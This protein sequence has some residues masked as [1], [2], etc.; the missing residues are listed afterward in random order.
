MPLLIF[1]AFVVGMVLV[2][3]V[4]VRYVKRIS[5]IWEA[6]AR[7]LGLDFEHPR[8]GMPRMFGHIR[9]LGVKVDVF[10]QRS[11]KNSQTF[12]RYR[13]RFPSPGFDFRLSRQTG[14]SRISKLFGAQDVTLG[15]PGFDQ[16]FIVKTGDESRL[17]AWL[18]PHRRGVLV[19]I[20]SSYPGV[21][22]DDGELRYQKPGLETSREVLVSTVRR[23]VDAADSLSKMRGSDRTADL[24]SARARGQLAEV[25]AR[26]RAAKE[27]RETTLDEAIVEVDTL[28][29]AGRR[30][31]ARE[32]LRMLERELPRDPEVLGWKRRLEAAPATDGALPRDG[33]EAEELAEGLF[34]GSALSFESKQVFDERYRGSTVRWTGS[35]KSMSTIR[36][37][38]DLGPEGATRLVVTI[39]AI[40]HDLYGNTEI[41]AVLA[42]PAGSAGHLSRGDKVSFSG[43]LLR[44]DPMVRN[45]FVGDAVLE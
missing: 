42:L 11:G 2:V 3:V 31:E 5:A 23:L 34:A 14:L 10:R 33:P 1:F 20:A 6:T 37:R 17:R 36:A 29:T 16:T 40:E 25:A 15:E 13:A 19:R 26:L 28:A 27:K 9:T 45:V 12:T 41:D 35:M 8:L 38:S 30:D 32:R 22:V 44:V 7:D 18:S 4:A 24:T 39:A 43:T 21:T